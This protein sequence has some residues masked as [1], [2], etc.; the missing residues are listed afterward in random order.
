MVVKYICI[1]SLHIK[2]DRGKKH[3]QIVE[4]WSKEKKIVVYLK[5]IFITQRCNKWNNHNFNYCSYHIQRKYNAYRFRSAFLPLET[6][7]WNVL[8]IFEHYN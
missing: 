8:R 1:N 5:S 7:Q 3:L 2:I 4:H 6:M